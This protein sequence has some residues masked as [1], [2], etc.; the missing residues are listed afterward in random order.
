METVLRVFKKIIP[1]PVFRFFQGPYHYV[2][3]FL[4][5]ILYGM[6]SR[7][8][9]VIGITGTKGKTTTCHL[10]A[11][12]LSTSG[13]KVGMTSS[14]EFRVGD[15]RRVNDLK[16][17]MPGRFGLQKL[18]R[19]MVR[20][21]CKYAVIETTSEGMLQYRHRFVNYD[22]A[23]FTNL[24]PEHIER[25]GSFEKYR[26]TK[27]KLFQKVARKKEGIG[28]YNFD[29]SSIECF[30]CPKIKRKIGYSIRGKN[31][32]FRIENQAVEMLFTKGVRLGEEGSQFE[33]DGVKFSVPLV[34]EF[35]VYN[36]FGA[37]A[38]A[39]AL[40]VS[41]E[42]CVEALRHPAPVAGR[43][44]IVQREPFTVIV[45]YAHEPKSLEES[46]KTALLF[47][48]KKQ[49]NK[50]TIKQ[51]K[52][53]CLLGSQGGGRDVWKREEMGKVA[54]KYC[55][56]VILSNEDP[57]DEDPLEIIEAVAKGVSDDKE[58]YKIVDRREGIEKA[59]SLAEPG[60]VVIFSAK[61]GEVWMVVEGGKKIPW[62]ERKV[63]E[64]TL[65]EV[66]GKK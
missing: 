57:Y 39:R 58:V 24:S 5:H 19:E 8:M 16:Q 45:D 25:H 10:L 61:G 17:G 52:L 60:D 20:A 29:D 46:Y 32:E 64:T 13:E 6:P 33:I 27:V 14:V 40:G 15:D 56:R 54:S 48:T 9:T 12:I 53:I 51:G 37:I 50:K 44:E 2:F 23:V 21:G 11:D 31:L 62:D 41:L 35:N 36:A 65:R 59:I 26:D 4:A 63:V 22:V 43:F 55:D 28:V 34:G 49:K 66:R 30:L 42:Q 38:T 7:K 47:C 18:L 1:G 3:A